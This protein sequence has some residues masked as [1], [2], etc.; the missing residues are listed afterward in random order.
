MARREVARSDRKADLV[1]QLARRRD[2]AVLL[3]VEPQTGVAQRCGATIRIFGARDNCNPG[4]TCCAGWRGR[5]SA[6]EPGA[7]ALGASVA[8]SRILYRLHETMDS[9]G[10]VFCSAVQMPLG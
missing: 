10:S 9:V 1:V 2:V 8:P 6:S 5:V 4:I 3:N 7:T